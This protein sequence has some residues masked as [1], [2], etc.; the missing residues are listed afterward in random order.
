MRAQ[1]PF[2]AGTRLGP[3]EIIAALGDGGM[4]EVYRGRDTRLDRTVAIKVLRGALAA[5]AESRQRFEG[6]REVGARVD[7]KRVRGRTG[8]WCEGGRE[9]GARVDGK[10]VRGRTGS[11][12]EG[13]PRRSAEREGG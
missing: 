13:W 12:R 7:G 4:G 3:Y 5:D 11:W 6:R 1:M 2:E 10:L 8:T 9:A